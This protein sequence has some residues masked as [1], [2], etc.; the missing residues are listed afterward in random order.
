MKK[1]YI[2]FIS[3]NYHKNIEYLFL[4]PYVGKR[5]IQSKLF[6]VLNISN[7]KYIHRVIDK[8]PYL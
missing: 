2:S 5:I 7:E 3:K 4:N 1:S 6:Y 8:A